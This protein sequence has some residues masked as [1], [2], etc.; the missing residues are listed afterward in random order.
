MKF[1]R[2]DVKSFRNGSSIRRAFFLF[3][4]LNA[5]RQSHSCLSIHFRCATSIR[6]RLHRVQEC[7]CSREKRGPDRKRTLSALNAHFSIYIE[8]RTSGEIL[9]P[10]LLRGKTPR[11]GQNLDGRIRRHTHHPHTHTHT[12]THTHIH[13]HTQVYIYI[14]RNPISEGW[15]TRAF[16]RDSAFLA[17]RS[18]WRR[19][20]PLKFQTWTRCKFTSR[21]R[22][23]RKTREGG[24]RPLNS[25]D[26]NRRRDRLENPTRIPAFLTARQCPSVRQRGH[27]RITCED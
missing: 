22:E 4:N 21:P 9:R 18:R 19:R 6:R 3:F 17:R 13:T 1:T 24:R 20:F 8:Q 25:T 27:R 10:T 16:K 5:A 12:H 23:K 7:R 14:Q 11:K 2:I 15:K 26:L